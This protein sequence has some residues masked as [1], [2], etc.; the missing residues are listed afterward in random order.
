MEILKKHGPMKKLVR[1]NQAPYMTK[2][3]HKE[4]MRR[5]E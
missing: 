5:S 2:A 1:A 4:I 3:L